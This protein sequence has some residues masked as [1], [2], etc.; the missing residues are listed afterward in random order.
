MDKIK[1]LEVIQ[2]GEIGGGESHL[3]TLLSKLDRNRFEPIVIALSDGE[4]INRLNVMGIKN[5]VVNSRLPFNFLV[6]KK[7]RKILDENSIDIIHTHGARALSNIIYP[8]SMLKIPVV[9]T[10]HGWS[11]HDYLPAWKRKLRI[12]GEKFLTGKTNMNIV[13]S[14]SNRKI[15]IKELG[16]F[17]CRVV[18]NGVDLAIYNRHAKGMSIRK[19]FNIPEKALLVSF[20]ARFIHDKNPLPLI[21]AFK[22]AQQ[23]HPDMYMLMV[24]N[25]PARAEAMK[26]AGELAISSHVL[27]PGFRSDVPAILA[28]SDVFCL[29]SIKEGLPVSLIEAMAMGNAVI[30]TA[31]QGCTDVVTDGSDGLLVEMKGLE[32]GLSSALQ[33][34]ADEPEFLQQMADAGRKTVEKRFDAIMMTHQIENIYLELIS[35][36]DTSK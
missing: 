27:F 23:N 36:R 8:A 35:Q 9:H 26:L 6:W 5:Y 18:N 2:Q 24:G 10:V 20:V 11:F 13:V 14:E 19:E 33:R 17:S 7:M 31:V 32:S 15:G 25:G 34:F 21:R 4:M 29:P 12:K 28:A 22:R 1:V 30:A 16:D 3:L